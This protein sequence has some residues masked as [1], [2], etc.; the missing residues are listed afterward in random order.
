[1]RLTPV[2]LKLL[3]KFTYTKHLKKSEEEHEAQDEEM[4]SIS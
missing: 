4:K 1:M 2:I 3:A